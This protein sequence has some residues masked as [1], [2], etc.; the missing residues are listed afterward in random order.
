MKTKQKPKIVIRYLENFIVVRNESTTVSITNGFG[1]RSPG[2]DEMGYG[3]KI[4]T[5]M[6]VQMKD[7]KKK[8]RVYCTCFSNAGS[9]WITMK[10][11]TWHLGTV[12]QDEI[13]EQFL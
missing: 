4:T 3:R 8:Y 2:Q 7:T 10:K 6:M 13:Q 5:D 1:T 9:L 12:F 11:Q